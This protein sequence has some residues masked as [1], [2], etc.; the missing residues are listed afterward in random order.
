MQNPFFIVKKI[1]QLC[2]VVLDAHYSGRQDEPFFLTISTIRNRFKV[3]M[4]IFTGLGTNGLSKDLIFFK[5]LG[6]ADDS[7]E[8]QRVEGCQEGKL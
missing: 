6:Q 3:K 5:G 4:R 8:R 7:A 2:P 1:A